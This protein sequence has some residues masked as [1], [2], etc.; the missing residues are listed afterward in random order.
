MENTDP[1]DLSR[2]LQPLLFITWPR[3]VTAYLPYFRLSGS[4]APTRR[5]TSYSQHTIRYYQ[6]SFVSFVFCN[7][8]PSALSWLLPPLFWITFSRPVKAELSCLWLPSSH[9][10]NKR[11]FIVLT[12]WLLYSCVKGYAL[13]ARSFGSGLPIFV[14]VY[15]LILIFHCI[16]FSLEFS[17]ALLC[18]SMLI[19][20][21]FLPPH[22]CCLEP[23]T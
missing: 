6:S 12:T 2:L 21:P 15:T 5:L 17:F 20:H 1:R 7:T 13:W 8:D 22:Q 23:H 18:S 4:H 14:A 19:M 11:V 16:T 3:P 10:C 9:A